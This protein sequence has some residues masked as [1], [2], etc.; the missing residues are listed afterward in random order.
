M[1]KKISLAALILSVFFSLHIESLLERGKD[2]V[3]F[4]PAKGIKK[5]DI[6]NLNIFADKNALIDSMTIYLMQIYGYE[7]HRALYRKMDT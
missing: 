1:V 2:M 7:R 4:A 6:E 3:I 5:P